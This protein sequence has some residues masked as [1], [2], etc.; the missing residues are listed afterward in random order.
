MENRITLTQLRN[1]S[2]RS[3]S[4][5]RVT[6]FTCMASRAVRDEF[7]AAYLRP[8]VLSRSRAPW[9]VLHYCSPDKRVSTSNDLRSIR[10]STIFFWS[11]NAPVVMQTSLYY[12]SMLLATP[13]ASLK[14]KVQSVESCDQQCKSQPNHNLWL[15]QSTDLCSSC[16]CLSRNT[17]TSQNLPYVLGERVRSKAWMKLINT[18]QTPH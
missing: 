7:R 9:L 8:P 12:H 5:D 15:V 11:R 3:A 14:H 18:L 13:H 1:P 17:N 6:R 2:I 16:S 10:S 4:G